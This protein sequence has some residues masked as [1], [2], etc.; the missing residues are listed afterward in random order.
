[1]QLVESAILVL[2]LFDVFTDSLFVSACRGYEIPSRPEVVAS[3]VF[4]L[5]EDKGLAKMVSELLIEGLPPVLRDPY[6]V[7]LSL[8]YGVA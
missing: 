1:M 4:L 5:P 6:H 3:E 7:E 2:L 8:P